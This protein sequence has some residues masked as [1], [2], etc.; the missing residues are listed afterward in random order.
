M[1]KND[2]RYRGPLSYRHMMILGWLCVVLSQVSLVL[3]TAGKLDPT[4]AEGFAGLIQIGNF[5][6][7]LFMPLLLL[8]NF[9]RIL[10]SKQEFKTLL[11]KF[12]GLSVAMGLAMPVIY[13]HYIAGFADAAGRLNPEL[14]ERF[15]TFIQNQV[16]QNGYVAY[17]IF[18]DL[19]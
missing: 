11:L 12:G 3:S 2:I 8:A 13:E 9:S 15:L 10:S 1:E 5:A 17:N 6:S 4:V 19:F 18:I 14:G 16:L 7:P